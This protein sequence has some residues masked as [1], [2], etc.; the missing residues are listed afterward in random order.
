MKVTF[1][2][3]FH[4]VWGQKLCVVGSIPELGSW[5]PALAKEMNY[6]GDGNWKLELDLPPDIKDIEYRYFLSVNDK[7]IFEEW[8]KNHRI[9]LDGQSDSYILYDYWQIRP[10]NLAFY[11]SAFTKSLFP[12]PCNTHE[13]VV[14]T[15]RK[16]EECCRIRGTKC[17]I[18]YYKSYLKRPEREGTC[19]VKK[20]SLISTTFFYL[21]Y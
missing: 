7:Q 16:S 9:V 2:I 1:N 17:Y 11:S 10:D 5:E 18:L 15:G 8:E 4:T 13:R 12:H 19:K 3:N 6:S 20:S 21:L 14:R